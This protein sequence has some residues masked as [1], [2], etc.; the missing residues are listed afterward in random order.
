MG[1]MHNIMHVIK[2][3]EDCTKC[4]PSYIHTQHLDRRQNIPAIPLYVVEYS[5]YYTV[6][7]TRP[8]DRLTDFCMTFSNNNPSP[9]LLFTELYPNPTPQP[10]V[11]SL[12]LYIL[13][14][15]KWACGP[16][17]NNFFIPTDIHQPATPSMATL[18]LRPYR[19]PD[20]SSVANHCRVI[21][22]CHPQQ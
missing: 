1:R 16:N 20:L 11:L 15:S 5:S 10:L 2:L 13:S 22:D 18:L 19:H 6:D 14:V 12:C 8:V 4:T 21:L 17:Q 3:S 7:V 9:A